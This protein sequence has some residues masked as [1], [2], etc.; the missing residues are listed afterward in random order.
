MKLVNTLCVLATLP[1][2]H[3]AQALTV[4]AA[5]SLTEP[6]QHIATQYEKQHKQNVKL[7]FAA[8]ST[9]ARQIANG[10]PADIYISANQKW[11]NYLAKQGAIIASTRYDLVHNQ[12]VLIAPASSDQ[13]N[14]ELDTLQ[15]LTPL[16]QGGRLALGNVDHV[17]V[18]IYARQAL[19][20][21]TLWDSVKSHLAMSS[22]TRAALAFVERDATPLGIVYASDAHSSKQVRVLATFPDDSHEPIR[23]PVAQINE[24]DPSNT[25]FLAYLK[26][27]EAQ[28]SLRRYGFKDAN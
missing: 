17:P 22:N 15:S 11:M 1:L 28:A 14:V 27:E 16:L 2:S 8:S 5:A 19:R 23:Y 26:T 12:L 3:V 20:K 10:A 18:G 7:V 4:Y 9:L 13:A 21:L 24:K 6:L 25:A